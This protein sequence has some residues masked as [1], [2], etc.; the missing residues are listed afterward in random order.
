MIKFELEK[1]MLEISSL[2]NYECE[3]CPNLLLPRGK[4]N[5]DVGLLKKIINETKD[6][7]KK[8]ILWNYGEPFMHPKIVDILNYLGKYPAIKIISTN[9]SQFYK[10]ESLDFIKNIDVLVISVNGITQ[11]VYSKHQAKGELLEVLAQTSR[12]TQYLKNSNTK[13]VLQMVANSYNIHQI[14]LLKSFAKKYN[15]DEVSI[16][17]FN[18]MNGSEETFSKYVPTGT[19]YSRY[20]K[21]ISQKKTMFKSD[22]CQSGMVINWNGEINLCCWD[23]QGRKIIGNAYKQNVR[24][25]WK[26]PE[27]VRLRDSIRKGEDLS[28]CMQ[29][30][31][32]RIIEKWE[33][34]NN[35]G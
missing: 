14:P 1:L 32:N 22:F 26:D 16:K 19:I 25:V 27:N 9:G 30:S 2:C 15:F 5:M 6:H 34:N 28:F 13:V 24:D 12:V 18:V 29:C 11:D 17:S 8:L 7:V 3:G 31:N 33:V 10:F 23:Y 21:K 35:Q 20:K 4:G